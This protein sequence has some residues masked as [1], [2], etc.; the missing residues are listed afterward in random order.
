MIQLQTQVNIIDNSGGLIGQC[1]K[2]LKPVKKVA[3]VGDLILISIKKTVTASGKNANTSDKVQKKEVHKALVVRTIF[4]HNN[5]RCEDNA[6]ILVKTST[7]NLDYTPIGSRIKGP[8]HSSL[9]YKKG[10]QKVLAL[11]KYTI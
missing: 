3:S 5:I 10:C 9:R 8:I 4:P 7:K 6:V 1:I 11:A 2:I